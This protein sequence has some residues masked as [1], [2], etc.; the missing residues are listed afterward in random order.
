MHGLLRHLESPASQYS[1]YMCIYLPMSHSMFPDQGL[2]LCH[3]HWRCGVLTPGPP[4]KSPSIA[5]LNRGLG[6]SHFL[7]QKENSFS[8]FP[9]IQYM[10]I[11]LTSDNIKK[12]KIKI[13]SK[14]TVFW[15]G[16]FQMSPRLVPAL[17]SPRNRGWVGCRAGAAP[18]LSSVGS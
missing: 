11:D 5:L 6:F 17:S 13:T 7:F 14:P 4:G 8:A 12:L 10:L 18:R 16:S 1:I 9:E 2:I 3:L 15:W